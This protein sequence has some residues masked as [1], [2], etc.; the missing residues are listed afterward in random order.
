MSKISIED[1][2]KVRTSEFYEEKC[3]RI[4]IRKEE[5]DRKLQSLITKYFD[6][7]DTSSIF[8]SV[9]RACKNSKNDG[10]AIE[11]Y[12]NLNRNDFVKWSKFVPFKADENGYNTNAKPTECC[13]R[14]L[15]HAKEDGYLPQ[16]IEFEVW[17]NQKFTVKFT[18]YNI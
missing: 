11:F 17:K 18:M 5:L 6:E 2:K 16:N 10:S 8:S 3:K 4:A 9:K 14:F 12:M 7:N 1:L 13:K 15:L